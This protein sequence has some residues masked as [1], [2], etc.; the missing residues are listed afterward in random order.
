MRGGDLGDGSVATQ[1][2]L[3]G[4][5]L[6]LEG[7]KARLLGVAAE[8]QAAVDLDTT[9]AQG[10]LDFTASDLGTLEQF[11]GTPL[12]GAAKGKVTL[13]AKGSHQ[14]M[15]A[16]LTLSGAGTDGVAL[17]QAA[18]QLAVTDLTDALRLDVKLT[19]EGVD[20]G[21]ARLSVVTV[22]AAGPLNAIA[23]SAGAEGE[24]FRDPLRLSLEGKADASG[25]VTAVT[26]AA[27]EVTTGPDQG[28][29][30][31]SDTVRLRQPLAIRIGGSVTADGLDLDLP[32]GG[33]LTGKLAQ[34]PGGF[35]GDLVLVALPL[36]VLERWASAP[37]K[38]GLLDLTAAF[39]TR[40]G[41]A[42]AE[43]TARARGIGFEKTVAAAGLL[44]LDL[45][46]GWD[47]AEMQA[48]TELRGDFGDPVRAQV[49]LPLRPGPG[50]VPESASGL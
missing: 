44:D 3:E 35:A 30:Q 29:E 1:F 16:D 25:E 13:T 43:I 15:A 42:G 4:S 31:A 33:R 48:K 22:Q 39:D 37:V 50:G 23:F 34:H 27:A 5:A 21:E 40:P 36:A 11:T 17:D 20:A 12:K 45:D 9:L 49:S 46:A 7:L 24:L 38:A 26:L 19:A 6:T 10:R 18:L 32:E 47:G 14:D 8:G 28:P 41:R 2:R